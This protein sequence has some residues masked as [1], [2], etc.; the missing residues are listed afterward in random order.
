MENSLLRIERLT[1]ILEAE[2]SGHSVDID[3]VTQLAA[4][5]AEEYPEMALSMRQIADR[6]AMSGQRQAA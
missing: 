3:E 2:S 4:D 6:I 5:L 1:N